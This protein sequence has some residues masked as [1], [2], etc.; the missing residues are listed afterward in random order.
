MSQLPPALHIALVPRTLKTAPRFFRGYTF[1]RR[2][3][4]YM[5]LR[6]YTQDGILPHPH[7]DVGRKPG[8]AV[9]ASAVAP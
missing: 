5:F 4:T 1:L 6:L 9:S 8:R 3:L 2:V 7:V